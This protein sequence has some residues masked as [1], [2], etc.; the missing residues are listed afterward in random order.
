MHRLDLAMINQIP[1]LYFLFLSLQEFKLA[2]GW[3]FSFYSV[4]AS[5]GLVT[6]RASCLKISRAVTYL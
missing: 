1:N 3:C 4:L 6:G 2:V 5:N